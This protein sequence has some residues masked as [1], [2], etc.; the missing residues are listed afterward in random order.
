MSE[1][2][3]NRGDAVTISEHSAVGDSQGNG[4]IE[5]A[6]RTVEEMLRTLK[7]DLESRV[8][9]TL[10]ITHLM[11]PWLME[12]AFDVVNKDQ[13][14]R[15]GKSFER[16]KRETV[17]RKHSSIFQ[18]GHG[19]LLERYKVEKFL[20]SGSKG[21]HVGMRFHTHEA[22]VMRLFDGMMVRTWAIQRQ[23]REV[24]KE[25]PSWKGVPWDSTGVIRARADGHHD[26]EHVI[27]DRFQA[28]MDCQYPENRLQDV[29]HK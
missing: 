7:L 26:D 3:R 2:A 16:V 1:V 22:V 10:K 13:V 27:R 11:L 21:F 19:E 24:T 5:R 15:D 18:F 23:E 6:V 14:G 17:Q 4:F 20:K 9:E 8:S 29:H 25:M 12:H 28:E